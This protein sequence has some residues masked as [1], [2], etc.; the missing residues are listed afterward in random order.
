MNILLDTHIA[1]WAL[2]DDKRLSK[3][4]RDLFLDPGNNL[5]YSAVSV[6][7]VDIKT[8]SRHNN[9][10]F[11]ANDFVE[12]CHLAGYIPAPMKEAYIL[13]AGS[14][15]WTGSDEEHKDPFDRLLLAQAITENMG[16]ITSDSKIPGF[17]QNC[18]ISV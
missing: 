17:R 10:S 13:R 18:V 2:T 7:E 14:L 3:K 8:K 12:M 15:E 16:F 5:F 6:F 1:I 11:S 4:A 9:L